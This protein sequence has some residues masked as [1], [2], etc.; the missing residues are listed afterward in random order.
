MCRHFGHAETNAPSRSSTNGERES[1]PSRHGCRYS[2]LRPSAAAVIDG[3]FGA[4]LE[5]VSLAVIG[6]QLQ[7]NVFQG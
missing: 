2:I 6:I 3:L 1:S 5:V 7:A 4:N